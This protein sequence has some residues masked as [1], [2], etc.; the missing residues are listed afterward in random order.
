MICIFVFRQEFACEFFCMGQVSGLQWHL[1]WM[2]MM[3]VVVLNERL[4]DA[5]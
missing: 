1:P 2:V 4:Q 5:S 3:V